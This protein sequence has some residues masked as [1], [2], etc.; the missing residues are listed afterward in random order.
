MVASFFPLFSAAL[1]AVD[2]CPVVAKLESLV[3]SDTLVGISLVL[4]TVFVPYVI[5]LAET[6]KYLT[7][8]ELYACNDYAPIT[9]LDESALPNLALSPVI[10]PQSTP[11]FIKLMAVSVI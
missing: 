11:L 10:Y 5:P 3:S 2:T 9:N 1:A 6:S 4:A 8:E 7:L